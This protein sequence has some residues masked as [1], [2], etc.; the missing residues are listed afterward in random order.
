MHGGKHAWVA[1]WVM[2]HVSGS[3]TDKG[4][5][6]SHVGMPP[7]A[8]ACLAEV[9]CACAGVCLLMMWHAYALC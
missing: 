7:L 2:A 3:E 1:C 8:H 9:R 5:F 4:G 6:L